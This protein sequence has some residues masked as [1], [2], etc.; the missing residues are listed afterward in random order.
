MTEQ[1]LFHCQIVGISV[2]IKVEMLQ[3]SLKGKW[4]Q[5]DLSLSFY[6]CKVLGVIILISFNAIINRIIIVHILI[7]T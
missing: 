7:I 6:H 5:M 4:P 3:L 1:T 2:I